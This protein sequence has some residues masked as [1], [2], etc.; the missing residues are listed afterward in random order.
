MLS[1]LDLFDLERSSWSVEEA[2]QALGLPT[3][4]AY[5]YVSSLSR[6]GMLARHGAARYVLG[7]TIIRYDRQLRLTDPLITAA[8]G[9]MDTLAALRPGETVVFLCR[10]IGRQV[11]CVHQAV[12]GDPGFATS[13]ERGRLM[14]LYAGSASKVILAHLP[15]RHT[16]AMYDRE[17]AAFAGAALGETWTEVKSRLRALRSG[18]IVVTSGE[19]D[20]GMRGLSAPVTDEAGIV[21]ASL[22]I[23]GR[24]TVMDPAAIAKLVGPLRAS[25]NQILGRVPLY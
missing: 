16:R 23:A 18:E 3:S 4:T 7:P 11:M 2:A 13:Y 9:E 22:S 19:I 12:V 24:D 8:R 5:R 6:Y 21:A 20:P 1:V 14:P 15:S 25:A 17:P 10:L